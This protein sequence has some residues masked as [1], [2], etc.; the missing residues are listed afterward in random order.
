VFLR[1]H[2]ARR[3]GGV[4]LLAEHRRSP[5][6][7]SRASISSVASASPRSPRRARRGVALRLSARD[8]RRP[9]LATIDTNEGY[10]A[11][12]RARGAASVEPRV[13]PA[14]S[15]NAL[16]GECALVFGLTGPS[17]AVSSSLD[18][19]TEA[20]AAGIEL[21]AAG[22][23]DRLVVVAADDAGPVAHD[24][25]A[26]AGWSNRALARGAVAILLV[27]DGTKALR[28]VGFDLASPSSTGPVG[29]LA[30]RSARPLSASAELSGR[31]RD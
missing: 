25:L 14:T 21:V 12:R 20:L 1:A 23:T 15:P 24:L 8:R 30:A 29:H 13:F 27:A 17:F 11:R 18:G 6:I 10:D 22:D 7:A 28:E 19:A 4:R 3:R 31:F 2:S 5:A 16:V 9:R 26:L